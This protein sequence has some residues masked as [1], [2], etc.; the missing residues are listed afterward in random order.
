MRKLYKLKEWY[1]LQD[2]ASRLTPTLGE[3]VSENDRLQL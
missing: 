1:S 2:A 3:P